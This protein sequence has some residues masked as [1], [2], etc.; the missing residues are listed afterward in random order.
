M[1]VIEPYLETI[2]ADTVLVGHSLGPAFILSLLEKINVPIKACFFV[3]GWIG[4]LGKEEFD[5]INTTLVEKDFDWDKIKQNCA[6]FTLYGSDNDPY[7]PIDM[8]K[9]LAKR[10][11]SDLILMEGAG[12][13]NEKAGYTKFPRLLEDIGK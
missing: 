11:D 6:E 2:D 9:D 1:E 5:S 12:H 3:A 7:I 4:P 8:E 10:L 13:F